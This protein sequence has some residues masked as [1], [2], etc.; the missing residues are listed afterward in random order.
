[1]GLLRSS[2]LSSAPSDR[3]TSNATSLFPYHDPFSHARPSSSF[4]GP[5]GLFPPSNSTSGVDQLGQGNNGTTAETPG[6]T[7]TYHGVC[8]TVWS[9]ADA[10]R[11]AA[12]RRTLEA[13]RSR[14][15]SAQSHVAKTSGTG[16]DHG[17]PVVLQMVKQTWMPKR[18]V[19]LAKVIMRWGALGQVII[20]LAR[21]HYFFLVTLYFGSRTL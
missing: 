16:A 15:E 18:T 8:L 6:S 13:G 3:P 11:S 19:V 14:K 17:P 10:E 4:L 20:T 7:I 12:I 1:M 9:H 2:V 5:P 21:A